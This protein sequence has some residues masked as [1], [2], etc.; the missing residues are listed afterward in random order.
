M[1]ALFFQDL[2]AILKSCSSKE[3]EI[4]DMVIRYSTV[5][6]KCKLTVSTRNSILDPRCFRESKIEFHDMFVK[7]HIPGSTRRIKMIKPTK[8]SAFEG[9]ICDKDFHDAPSISRLHHCKRICQFSVNTRRPS[10][11][12]CILLVNDK[13]PTK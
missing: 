13:L 6:G 12:I 4:F 10:S 3:R 2:V 1:I 9:T 7:S 5:P 8:H 11:G